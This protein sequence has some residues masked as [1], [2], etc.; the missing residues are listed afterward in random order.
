[1]LF[2]AVAKSIS[3]WKDNP[4]WTCLYC[5]TVPLQLG[6]ISLSVTSLYLHGRQFFFSFLLSGLNKTWK[7]D[8]FAPWP[9]FNAAGMPKGQCRIFVQGIKWSI[10]EAREDKQQLGSVW[11]QLTFAFSYYPC[12]LIS[13][14]V[15]H[16]GVVKCVFGAKVG[17]VYPTAGGS[18][19]LRSMS[20]SQ[21]QRR[22]SHRR[23]ELWNNAQG[24]KKRA[25]VWELKVPLSWGRGRMALCSGET[26]I[27][28][29]PE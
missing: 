9:A 3:V 22:V 26:Q 7:G 19:L 27:Y 5:V 4:V 13:P 28:A 2:F 8:S 14:R 21:S 29:L 1:M 23:D 16:C 20:R 25:F 6:D 18:I 10:L 17:P 12:H 24:M 15:D 11:L